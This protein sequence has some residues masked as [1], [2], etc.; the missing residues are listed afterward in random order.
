MQLE[1][2]IPLGGHEIR[3]GHGPGWVVLNLYAS[4]GNPLA[5]FHG[6]P[7]EIESLAR[8]L[9]QRAEAARSET[10]NFNEGPATVAGRRQP[11]GHQQ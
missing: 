5:A 11:K 8:A 2:Q 9:L 4:T 3:L 7:D 10:A 6:D 1:H